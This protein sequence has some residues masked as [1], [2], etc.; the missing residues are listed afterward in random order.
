MIGTPLILS[1]IEDAVR[2]V[3]AEVIAFGPNLLG[4]LLVLLVGLIIGKFVGGIVRRL[5][6]ASRLDRYVR[7]TRVGVLF[8]ADDGFS[9]TVGKI[10]A[11]YIYLVALLAAT[12]VLGIAL[13]SQW[14]DTAVS[15]L[16][17][18]IAG[19]LIIFLGLI[20]ADFIANIIRKSPTS[21]R[22]GYGSL[23]AT[24]VQLFL[25]FVVITIGLGTMGIDVSILLV[26]AGAFVGALGLAL[27]LG[28]GLA[29]G[30]GGKEYVAENIDRWTSQVDETVSEPE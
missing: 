23:L 5:I 2:D 4:A 27:A 12:D 6:R 8:E 22:T 15:Y 7:N 9:R 11:Y 10:T 16:P 29:V 18:I 3:I 21:V 14:L 17:A 26:L 13:L 25:Y 28:V 24:V 20:L 1:D 30:L 19:V